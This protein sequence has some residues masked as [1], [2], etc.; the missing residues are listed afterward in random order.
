MGGA[1]R[2]AERRGVCPTTPTSL[3]IAT[4]ATLHIPTTPTSLRR[5][6]PRRAAMRMA[7]AGVGARVCCWGG[8]RLKPCELRL[9]L[10]RSTQS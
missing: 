7:G 9:C 8:I 1:R 10:H 5:A 6:L 3:L 4:L 2:S